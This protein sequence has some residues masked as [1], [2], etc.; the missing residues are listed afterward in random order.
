MCR[1]VRIG[2]ASY[3]RTGDLGA[4]VNGELFVLGRIKE[5]VIVAGRNVYAHDIEA[6]VAKSHKALTAGSTIAVGI[7]DG[8]AEQLVIIQELKRTALRGLDANGLFT[9]IR[10]AVIE[11]HEIAP[12]AIVLVRPASL[13]RTTSGKLQRLKARAMFLA[14]TLAEV[15]SWRATTAASD[16]AMSDGGGAGQP[17]AAAPQRQAWA[18]EG[19]NHMVAAPRRDTLIAALGELVRD[20]LRLPAIPPSDVALSDLGMDSLMATELRSRLNTALRLDPPLPAEL[21][22]DT[23][24]LRA[25][26]AAVEATIARAGEAQHVAGART[27]PAPTWH[28]DL[29]ATLDRLYGGRVPQQGWSDVEALYHAFR[30]GDGAE[31]QRD[32]EAFFSANPDDAYHQLYRDAYLRR[33]PR[34]PFD[35]AAPV[36]AALIEVEGRLARTPMA[37]RGGAVVAALVAQRDRL[38]RAGGAEAVADGLAEAMNVVRRLGAERDM[39]IPGRLGS[40]HIVIFHA[41]TILAVD[42]GTLR[43]AQL[44]AAL[45]NLIDTLLG[46]RIPSG[47]ANLL[48]AVTVA[49]K[50]EAHRLLEICF[51]DRGQAEVC[52]AVEGALCVL[53][54]DP[55]GQGDPAALQKRTLFGDGT[56]RWYGQ[57]NLVLFGSP[58]I[59]LLADHAV[60]DGV[61]GT[62]LVSDLL[63][64]AEALMRDPG[65]SGA[66]GRLA[67]RTLDAPSGPLR[68]RLAEVA[69]Q[70]ARD[71]DLI[72]SL[73]ITVPGLPRALLARLPRLFV[74]ALCKAGFMTFGRETDVYSSVS[75]SHFPKGRVTGVR[76]HPPAT[77]ALV[78]AWHD[79]AQTPDKRLL[80]DAIREWSVLYGN[81]ATGTG[82]YTHLVLLSQMSARSGRGTWFFAHPAIR[83]LIDWP[84]LVS[85]GILNVPVPTWFGF[86][87]PPGGI[88]VAATLCR[89]IDGAQADL[90]VVA[91]GDPGEAEHFLASL[92]LVLATLTHAEAAVEGVGV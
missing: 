41:G 54:L 56:N 52:A 32:L 64:Q 89:S 13:P 11:A 91:M 15:T 31:L 81:A 46:R 29:R 65:A 61:S 87:A 76:G 33:R 12:H 66:S 28:A 53:V 77:S 55:D 48:P 5:M 25:L 18:G 35:P 86:P 9:A 2:R 70:A 79:P 3:L 83:D 68:E 24:T 74:I 51:A 22:F 49:E 17:E 6:T 23:P 59:G 78:R 44:G 30:Q 73:Q 42:L 8:S 37:A 34:L 85:S 38:L 19:P 63:T 82:L 1:A 20:V 43:D 57:L 21:R 71:T 75:L 62:R 36:V 50:H 26:A 88:S 69:E 67:V 4:V 39:L 10:R 14:A 90:R 72:R 58:Q 16:E 92:Q 45:A 80:M 84:P 47:A 27:L 7:D 60:F 40:Q